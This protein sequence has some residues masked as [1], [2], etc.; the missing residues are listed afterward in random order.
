ME[1]AIKHINAMN[2]RVYKSRVLQYQKELVVNGL[3]LEMEQ[4]ARQRK[5][6]ENNQYCNLM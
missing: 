6:D 2:K 1:K 4:H 3:S 5:S